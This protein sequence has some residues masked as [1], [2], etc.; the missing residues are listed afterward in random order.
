MK[1]GNFSTLGFGEVL[2]L[3]D[4]MEGLCDDEKYIINELVY[5]R[6]DLVHFA[7]EIE[8]ESVKL[9][10]AHS[11]ARVLSIFALGGARDEGEM[12]DYRRFLSESNFKDLI[13]F[14]PYRAE[15]VD[16]AIESL[17]T[18]KILK[19]YLCGNESFC[20]R[21]SDTYFCHCC[22]F[23]ANSDAIAFSDCSVCGAKERFCFD[24][25]NTTNNMYYGRCMDCEVK[26]WAWECQDCGTVVSQI[27][28]KGRRT[29]PTCEC[30]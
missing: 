16:A 27:E 15:A 18:E 5:L 17:D 8:T 12:R 24:P 13:N 21:P 30:P 9:S 6:N 14:E 23:R 11:L 2:N 26:Q 20:L 28:T 1:E 25:L 19:C 22:G 10:C 3:V 7:S 29:C 4:A